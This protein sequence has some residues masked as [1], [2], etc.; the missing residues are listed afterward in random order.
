MKTIKTT[1][2]NFTSALLLLGAAISTTAQTTWNYFISDAGGGN[3]LL[4]WNVTG[5]L[6]TPP[7]SV[8]VVSESSL[9]VSI[10][11]PGIYNDAYVTDGAPQSLP[12][13]DGSYFQY[14]GG[15]VYAPISLYYTDNAPGSGNDSFGLISP[16]L[17]HTG[18]GIQLLY[19]P[20]TQS[21]LIPVA[22]F[23]F[24]PGTYQ[25]QE[26]GFDTAITVNLTVEAVPEPS[27]LA[28]IAGAAI[29]AA[30]TGR[31]R[32]QRLGCIA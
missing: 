4:T 17:P 22:F 19:N 21:V 8:L 3:S 5:S 2:V 9:A 29:G 27:S 6:A 18:P 32:K 15:S 13:P 23:N 20:G 26:S 11:A 16:L 24:N 7:G 31:Q 14:D 1:F 12:V 25:S 30:L 28:L 10:I